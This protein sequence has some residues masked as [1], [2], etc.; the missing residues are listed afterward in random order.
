MKFRY[1]T[2]FE[3]SVHNRWEQSSSFG[4]RHNAFEGSFYWG[5]RCRIWLWNTKKIGDGTFGHGLLF[6]EKFWDK[7]CGIFESTE[8]FFVKNNLYYFLKTV[9]KLSTLITILNEVVSCNY[10]IIS[11]WQYCQTISIFVYAYNCAL[12]Q[13][14]SKDLSINL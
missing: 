12:L 14:H 8:V 7:I 1:I 2:Y 3:A 13:T 11:L 9:F 6:F 5:F 4:I 10:I